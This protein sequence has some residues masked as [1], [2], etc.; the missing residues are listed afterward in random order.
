MK[1]SISITVKKPCTEKFSNFSTTE[2]GGFCA[3]CEKEVIDFT[4]MSQTEV[5]EFQCKN[6]ATTCGRF[7]SSQLG[8]FT[9]QQNYNSMS[10]LITK[11]IGALSFSLLSLCAVS[12]VEAQEVAQNSSTQTELTTSPS[13]SLRGAPQQQKYTISGTVLDEEN[14]P[15]PG[16]SIVLKGTKDG[17]STDMDGKF[18]FPKTLEAN[19]VL[20]FS[21]IGY[22]TKEYKII[23]SE[24]DTQDVTIQFK[25]SDIELMGE[26]AIEGPYKTKRNIF[27]KFAAIFK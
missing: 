17:V 20:V 2:K 8:T 19:S 24:K 10:N 27:Q 21:Y 7:K 9:E 26:V 14:I 12:N 3:S 1:N 4:C 23:T 11:G 16:V 5:L 15:L 13:V 22:D 25:S 18:E 6:S